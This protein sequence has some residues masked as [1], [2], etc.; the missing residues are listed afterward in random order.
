MRIFSFGRHLRHG[1]NGYIVDIALS[2]GRHGRHMRHERIEFCGCEL[3][4]VL[5][6]AYNQQTLYSEEKVKHCVLV[7]W[8]HF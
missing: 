8:I 7:F 4:N 1:R 2:F 5:Q 3:Y 6:N